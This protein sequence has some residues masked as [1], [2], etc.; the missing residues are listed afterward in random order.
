MQEAGNR[1][2][3]KLGLTQAEFENWLACLEER[4]GGELVILPEY[5]ASLRTIADAG[6]PVEHLLQLAWAL[7]VSRR[8]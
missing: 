4:I 8:K 1:P 3:I 7:E 5:R 2:R 6:L